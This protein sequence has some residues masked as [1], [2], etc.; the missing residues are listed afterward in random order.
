ME[1]I[2]SGKLQVVPVRDSA[3]FIIICLRVN[4]GSHEIVIHRITQLVIL[5]L[6]L[7]IL[8]VRRKDPV[9]RIYEPVRTIGIRRIEYLSSV[10]I[11]IQT[12][13]AK[14]TVVLAGSTQYEPFQEVALVIRMGTMSIPNLQ[15]LSTIEKANGAEGYFGRVLPPLVRPFRWSITTTS[16][17][18]LQ[19]WVAIIA[20]LRWRLPLGLHRTRHSYLLPEEDKNQYCQRRGEAKKRK[21]LLLTRPGTLATCS[22]VGM[23]VDVRLGRTTTTV[24]AGRRAVHDVH[25]L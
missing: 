16:N 5:P 9:A 11:L 7:L 2:A 8:L 4:L 15:R 18:E 25:I 12:V 20:M 24:R 19:Q 17:H 21:H 10:V 6:L 13:D 22:I 23:A 14:N 1:H 3:F